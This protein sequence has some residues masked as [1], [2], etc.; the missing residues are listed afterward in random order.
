MSKEYESMHREFLK[1]SP[2]DKIDYVER[3]ATEIVLLLNQKNIEV[4]GYLVKIG[5]FKTFVSL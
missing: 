2:K 1:L 4:K 3:M 5:F